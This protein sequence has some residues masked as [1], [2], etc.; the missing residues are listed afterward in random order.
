[1]KLNKKWQQGQAEL[2]AISQ[3][4]ENTTWSSRWG[5]SGTQE[6]CGSPWGKRPGVTTSQKRL[7]P[8]TTQLNPTLDKGDP[9]LLLMFQNQKWM[10]LEEVYITQSLGL[11]LQKHKVCCSGAITHP[12]GKT[13]WLETKRQKTTETDPLGDED[14]EVTRQRLEKDCN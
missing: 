4:W 14:V 11:A 8:V 10:P 12:G 9:T 5:Q 3:S 6:G 7:E 13:K 1:M 2:L